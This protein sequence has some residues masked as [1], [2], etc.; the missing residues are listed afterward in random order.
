MSPNKMLC[1][2]GHLVYKQYKISCKLWQLLRKEVKV[3]WFVF[4][5][6]RNGRSCCDDDVLLVKRKYRDVRMWVKH[7]WIYFFFPTLY[8]FT[9]VILIY[10]R[11]SSCPSFSRCHRS[12]K[13][14]HNYSHSV[15]LT[16]PERSDFLHHAYIC[17]PN[18]QYTK[19]KV[20]QKITD[21]KQ[22]LRLTAGGPTDSVHVQNEANQKI[23]NQTCSA[24]FNNK[25][26]D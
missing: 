11:A 2:K 4:Y 6:F 24:L 22:R 7:L 9:S 5:E 1:Q 26:S 14:L 10:A 16:L 21:E 23:T 13:Q 18:N 20:P 15:S 19:Y 17:S 25:P 8:L 12:D 3:F